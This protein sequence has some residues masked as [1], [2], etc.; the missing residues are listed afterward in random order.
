MCYFT[1]LAYKISYWSTLFVC[2]LTKFKEDIPSIKWWW[3]WWWM[4]AVLDSENRC[5]VP[6][7]NTHSTDFTKCTSAQSPWHLLRVHDQPPVVQTTDESNET[8]AE[9]TRTH[10]KTA[11][12]SC[13]TLWKPRPNRCLDIVKQWKPLAMKYCQIVKCYNHIAKEIF[14][15][16]GKNS[17]SFG[18]CSFFAKCYY[19]NELHNQVCTVAFPLS[20]SLSLH[21]VVMTILLPGI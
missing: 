3:W 15:L 1:K 14:I 4:A 6:E 16:L 20:L 13:S 8:V 21:S 19:A 2:I 7:T 12:N 9:H 10:T 18:S 17:H 11:L 5:R